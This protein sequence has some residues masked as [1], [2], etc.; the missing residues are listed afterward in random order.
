MESNNKV[1]MHFHDQSSNNPNAASVNYNYTINSDKAADR[2]LSS[3]EMIDTKPLM[4]YIFDDNTRQ[5]FALV[6][7]TCK[8]A[9]E[10]AALLRQMIDMHMLNIVD[11]KSKTFRETIIPYLG[12]ETNENTL[13]VGLNTSL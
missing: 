9:V 4:K 10:A 7:G 1:E 3:Q 2:L 5:K 6:L 8:T 12:Y 13:R 11:V